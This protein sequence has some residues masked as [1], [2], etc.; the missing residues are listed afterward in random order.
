MRSEQQIA[1][2]RKALSE[3]SK[4]LIERRDNPAYWLNFGAWLALVWA[5]EEQDEKYPLSSR[6]NNAE[7]CSGHNAGLEQP[8]VNDATNLPQSKSRNPSF[9]KRVK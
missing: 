9:E 5:M 1:D 3:S 4:L 2:A 8:P 7:R 6:L